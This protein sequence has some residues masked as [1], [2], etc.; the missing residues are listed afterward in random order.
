MTTVRQNLVA[1][2]KQSQRPHAI[3]MA[4]VMAAALISARSLRASGP[5]GVLLSASRLEALTPDTRMIEASV[6]P[7]SLGYLEFDWSS[8]SGG[9]PGFA[10]LPDNSIT[11]AN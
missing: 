6:M 5:S 4:V 3:V 1:T 2:G 7:Q 9:V 10:P 11:R 8:A